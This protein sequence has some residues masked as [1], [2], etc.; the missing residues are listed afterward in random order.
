M[1]YLNTAGVYMHIFRSGV[2]L[3]T[4]FAIGLFLGVPTAPVGYAAKTGAGP[5]TNGK[6]PSQPDIQPEHVILFV[7]EG[8]G[9]DSLKTGAM[10][11]LNRLVKDG[12]VTWSATAVTPALRLPTMASLFT[13]MP[14]EK[15]GITWN[16]FDFIRG[17]P[18]PPTVFDYLDLSGGKDSAIFFMDES[19]YQLAK[20][21]PYTDY[22]MCGPLKPECSP[23]TLV[24]YIRQYFKKA[25]SGHGYGHAILS[26]PHFLVVHLPEP[27]RAGEA[28]GWNAKAYRD[29]LK[30]VD[31]AMG[32]VLDLYK[33]LGLYSRTTILVTSL[34]DMG[35]AKVNG[36]D[37]Q[38]AP[39]TPHVLW[40]ASGAGIKAG[41]TIAQPVSILDTGA[42]VLRT[43]GLET[44][45]EW[46]SHPVEEIFRSPR[47]AAAD[48]VSS[49]SVVQ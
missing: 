37:Q 28:E 8:V 31:A 33:E 36:N 32:S 46:D 43:L 9:K 3:T 49:P 13:G 21:E 12:S 23:A 14:V 35:S 45:T 7:L 24:S 10:P 17:Y 2:I 30:T 22:Q 26:L 40:L 11:V 25:T 48:Q 34:N 39:Q 18:R 5:S 1:E 47:T 19:L 15:H 29:A 38:A 41:H 4:V 16:A 6:S 44:Y 20:P 42:T 27:V